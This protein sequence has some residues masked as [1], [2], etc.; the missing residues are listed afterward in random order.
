MNLP[1]ALTASRL[2]L[3]GVL[4][5]LLFSGVPF[6]A[7]FALAVFAVAA[8]TDA[9]DGRLARRVYGVTA[10]GAL[11]DPL[12]D[13]VLVSAALVSF[14]QLQLLPAWIVVVILAREF[15]VTGLRV[16]AAGHG[17]SIAAGAWGK[18]KTAWQLV[19][20]VTLLAG[21]VVQRDVLPRVAPER[22]VAFT[23]WFEAVAFVVGVAAALI[24]V[25]SGGIYVHRHR[26][27]L[28]AG[29]SGPGDSGCG[30]AGAR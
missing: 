16:L 1:N 18:H 15:F 3:A 2:V 21:L 19:V 29:D 11:I 28:R 5:A 22:L 12:A 20:I 14:V 26:D 4:I 30:P 27:L 7:S 25:A 8:V 24:T 23:P 9:L 13:K 6:G 10:L 17:R